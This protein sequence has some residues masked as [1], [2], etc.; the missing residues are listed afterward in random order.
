[1]DCGDMSPLGKRGHV[2]ALQTRKKQN[3]RGNKSPP[4]ILET[5]FNAACPHG[6][7]WHGL[8]YLTLS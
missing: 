4:V 1:M 3:R 8:R 6:E 2:R 7:Q 5:L